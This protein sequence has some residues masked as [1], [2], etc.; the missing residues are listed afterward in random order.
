MKPTLA[1]GMMASDGTPSDEKGRSVIFVGVAIASAGVF[2]AGR[3]AAILLQSLGDP[4]FYER[5]ARNTELL[6]LPVQS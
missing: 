3:C 1:D 2:Q 6:R 5:L 4:H